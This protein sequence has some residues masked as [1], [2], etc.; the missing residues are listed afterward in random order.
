MLVS[1]DHMSGVASV[2]YALEKIGEDPADHELI[3]AVLA[4]VKAVGEKGR[5]VGVLELKDI[6]AWVRAGART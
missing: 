6:V 3:G 2:A 1:L 5:T 4:Q